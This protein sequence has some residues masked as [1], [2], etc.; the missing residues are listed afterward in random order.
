VLA[1]QS[2]QF[3]WPASLPELLHPAVV[4]WIVLNVTFVPASPFFYRPSFGL[5]RRHDFLNLEGRTN[6]SEP[7]QA[8][9]DSKK[10]CCTEA[11]ESASLNVYVLPLL[12]QSLQ[13]C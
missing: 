9:I 6:G 4:P 13:G 2:W 11:D 7:K 3:L 5:G 1:Q 8:V 10:S 12:N